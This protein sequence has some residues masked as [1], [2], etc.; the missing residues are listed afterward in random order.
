MRPVIEYINYRECIRDFYEEQKTRKALSW[1][2]FAES[3][4]IKSPVFLQYV[5]EGK[6][7]LGERTAPQVAH[8]M[9]LAGFESSF[10][11]KLVALDNAKSES[12]KKGILEDIAELARVH[13]V[14]PITAE[15]YQFFKSWK[16]SLIRELAPCMDGAT[17]KEISR[18]TRYRVKTGE[19][20]EILEFLQEAGYLTQDGQGNYRQADRSLR[21]G[22][23]DRNNAIKTVQK[24][25]AHDLQVQMAELATDALKNDPA[26]DRNI[27]GLT[28]GITREAYDQIV[29]ELAQC[30]RRIVA[31]ATESART[32]EVYRLNMQL[33][34]L[35]SLGE[36]NNKEL[37]NNKPSSRRRKK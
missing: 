16:N 34:P 6:K 1:A 36:T 35:T 2:S 5:C 18:A 13:K 10:F 27:T 14:K 37:S 28:L 29:E 20:R 17:P 30:R 15:E 12:D 26:Q 4:G 8:A 11:C 19:V 3:A 24:A 31:I 23:A 32:E 9:G 21:M 25:I 7:N 33:F 22:N